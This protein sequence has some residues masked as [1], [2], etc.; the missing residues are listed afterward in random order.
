MHILTGEQGMELAK[1]P[2]PKNCAQRKMMQA[3]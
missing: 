1:I 2:F 3:G